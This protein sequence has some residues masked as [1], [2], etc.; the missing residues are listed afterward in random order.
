MQVK[1]SLDDIQVTQIPSHPNKML[2]TGI[3][4][5]VGSPSTYAPCGTGGKL[6][7]LTEEA[8][9]AAAPSMVNMPLNCE[10]PDDFWNSEAHEEA[11]TGHDLDNVIGTVTEA[12]VD[13]GAFICSGIIWKQNFPDVAYLVNNAVESLG[14]SIEGNINSATEDDE[15]VTATDI[16][17]TGLATLWKKCAAWQNTEFLELVASRTNKDNQKQ[18][19]VIEDMNEEQM[20]A[21][22]GEFLASVETKIGALEDKVNEVV[23]GVKA[24]VDKVAENVETVTASIEE[25]KASVEAAKVEAETKVEE[26]PKIEAK[27]EEPVKAPEPTVL[28][29]GQSVVANKDL[30]Q[31]DEVEAKIAQI[32]ASTMNP[33]EKC[34]AITKLRLAQK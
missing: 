28:A 4:C 32:N 33:L 13:N 14:F 23:D 30:D 22:L 16:V 11:M 17:F 7:V 9:T 21:L 20:K 3:V 12:K 27:A 25:V 15:T 6:L 1:L 2:W 18:S 5:R 24:S 29:P 34:K 19:E 26:T 10:W 8:A 31:K